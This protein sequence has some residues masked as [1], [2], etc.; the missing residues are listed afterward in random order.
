MQPLTRRQ[1]LTWI[2]GGVAGLARAQ[3][4]VKLVEVARS[5]TYTEGP[6]FDRNG[7]L[8]F[9]HREGIFQLTPEGQLLDWIRDPAAGFHGHK[10]TADGSH[11]VCASRKGAVWRIRASGE[12]LDLAASECEGKP[13]R[14]PN[15][16]TLD[17]RHG[18]FYFTDPGGSRTEPAGSVYYTGRDGI[19]RRAAGAL[20]VPNGLV[21]D[22]SDRFLYVAE[23]APNRILRFP[24]RAPGELGPL[25]VFANLPAREGHQAA[26]DGLA[27]DETGRLYVAHLGTGIVLVLSPKGALVDRLPG[28]NYDVSNLVFGGPRLNSLYI[29]G[30]IGH[31]SNTEGRVYRLDLRGVRGRP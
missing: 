13:L 31:R 10:I 16:I 11:L 8:F 2:A 21:I 12:F 17:R 7:N 1:A 24:I 4:Q 15:D 27:V 6:V 3:G 26:P 19:T 5:P 9:S 23:T 29:T 25:E 14:E 20:R 22:P 28:G 30:S 18:G